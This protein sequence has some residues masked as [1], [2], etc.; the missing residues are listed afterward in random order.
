[1]LW[2]HPFQNRF[3]VCC[4]LDI[5]F[6]MEFT[7]KLDDAWNFAP[8]YDVLKKSE[9]TEE[10]RM[11]S[12]KS[13]AGI[14]FWIALYGSSKYVLVVLFQNF[15]NASLMMFPTQRLAGHTLQNSYKREGRFLFPAATRRCIVQRHSGATH[16]LNL[17]AIEKQ[18]GWWEFVDTQD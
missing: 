8:Q 5:V 9:L 13:T 2:S 12:T 17:G 3:G 6:Y 11:C 10:A 7:F 16:Y 4:P 1:M 14:S 18:Y 15:G